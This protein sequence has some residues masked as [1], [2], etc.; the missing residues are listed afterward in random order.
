M[1]KPPRRQAHT[2]FCSRPG[3]AY[4]TDWDSAYNSYTH[5]YDAF[6]SPEIGNSGFQLKYYAAKEG[7]TDAIGLVKENLEGHVIEWALEL[8]DGYLR[9]HYNMADDFIYDM[10]LFNALNFMDYYCN[11]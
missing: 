7:G 11:D 3:E 2:L 8:L 4:T 10:H 6:T 9:D 5:S 1:G